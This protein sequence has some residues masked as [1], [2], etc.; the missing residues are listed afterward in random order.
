MRPHL[1]IIP[2]GG[3]ALVLAV[4]SST[5]AARIEPTPQLTPTP[6]FF[7]TSSNSPSRAD[8]SF[9]RKAAIAIGRQITVSQ[10]VMDQ[11]SSPQLKSFAQQVISD[12]TL[13]ASDLAALA[14]QK[15]VEIPMRDE[16][17]LS[18]DWSKR[19]GDVDRQYV[20]E[21]ATDHGDAVE[22]FGE[23]AT[24][25]DPDVAAFAQKVLTTLQRRSASALD[26]QKAVD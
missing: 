7:D 4:L 9:M 2:R 3:A 5:L 21:M 8:R 13:A 20:K 15:G 26:L 12:D 17:P 14:K 19:T 11:L 16:S 24:S 18:D 25:G 6:T 23:A 10:V 1:G 22:L